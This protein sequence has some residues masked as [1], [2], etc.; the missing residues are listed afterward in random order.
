MRAAGGQEA[1]LE[2]MSTCCVRQASVDHFQDLWADSSRLDRRTVQIHQW[3]FYIITPTHWPSMGKQAP[4]A[5]PLSE[6]ISRRAWHRQTSAGLSQRVAAGRKHDECFYGASW[7]LNAPWEALKVQV[8][9]L[10]LSNIHLKVQMTQYAC[11]YWH[12]MVFMLC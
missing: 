8:R 6:R 11:K 10:D 12:L 4:L 7:F 3:G 9:Q 1:D 2:D 5:A